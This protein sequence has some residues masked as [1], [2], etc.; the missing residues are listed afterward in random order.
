M[1][2]MKRRVLW[3]ILGVLSVT[4][5]AYSIY[6]AFPRY[7]Y[8]LERT[9]TLVDAEVIAEER[10]IDRSY[11]VHLKSSTGLEVDMRV[12]RPE[13]DVTEKLPLVL[14]LGGQETGKD[15]SEKLGT[16]IAQLRAEGLITGEHRL[17]IR[18]DAEG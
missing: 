4:I 11:T 10:E 3:W 6:L 18:D 8:F 1:C 5:V 13:V 16:A 2:P 17:S 14:V 9:G 15:D 7:D 12:L